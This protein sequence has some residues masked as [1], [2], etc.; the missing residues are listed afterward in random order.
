MYTFPGYKPN[1]RPDPEEPVE[2][3][4]AIKREAI[5]AGGVKIL[6]GK[7]KV[8]IFKKIYGK[9]VYSEPVNDRFVSWWP[10]G[11]DYPRGAIDL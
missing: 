11:D 8:K 10:Y 7:G 1:T 2:I 4:E 5:H 9:V 6:V 3:D